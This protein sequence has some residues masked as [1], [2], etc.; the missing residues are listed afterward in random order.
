MTDALKK[1]LGWRQA[2]G[3]EFPD[4]LTVVCRDLVLSYVPDLIMVTISW[5][6]TGEY[7]D[8]NSTFLVDSEEWKYLERKNRLLYNLDFGHLSSFYIDCIN[9]NHAE[10]FGKCIVCTDPRLINMY[11]QMPFILKDDQS[12]RFWS[13]RLG[14]PVPSISSHIGSSCEQQ[15]FGKTK[16]KLAMRIIDEFLT[17]DDIRAWFYINSHAVDYQQSKKKDMT[18]VRIKVINCFLC[19][20][21]LQKDTK[22]ISMI[23][24]L[25]KKYP[26]E[27]KIAFS[28]DFLALIKRNGGIVPDQTGVKKCEG[29]DCTG[30]TYE[31]YCDSCPVD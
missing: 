19:H 20:A 2:V 1:T 13:G 28:D 15:G 26:Q 12:H 7:H 5:K 3:E 24:R 4:I 29:T 30:N 25:E 23:E 17:R 31:E 10:V 6:G 22:L 9:L 14:N 21:G 27:M 11:I 16:S 18:F 8:T